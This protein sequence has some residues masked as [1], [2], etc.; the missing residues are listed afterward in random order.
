MLAYRIAWEI[1]KDPATT[2]LYISSTSNL[3]EKQ[4]GAIKNILTS[5]V[6]RRYW[7][8]M[9]HPEEGKREKWSVGEF[10]VDHPLRKEEGVRDPTVFA[11]GLTTAITG[12]HCKIAALDDVVTQE[13]A[14]TEDGRRKVESQYSLLASIEEPDAKELVVGTRYHPRDLYDAMTGMREDVYDE[15]GNI[16]ETRQIYE[17]FE[18][19]VEDRGDGTGEFLWPRQQRSDGQWFGFNTQ[20]LMTKKAQ[21]LDKTQFYAQYYNDPNDRTNAPITPDKFQ[22]FDKKHLKEQGGNWFFKDKKLNVYAGIDFAYS[23]TRKADYTALVVIG[24]DPDNNIYVLDIARFKQDRVQGYY[25]E[26][27]RLYLK[28]SFKKLRAEVTAAQKV[29][30]RELKEKVKQDGYPIKIEEYTPTRNEGTKEERINLTL[31][32]RYDN[33]QVWHYRDG[34]CQ[35]LE[36]EL[37]L[38]FPPH[39]DVKDALASVV[40]IA[41]P[42]RQRHFETPFSTST[43]NLFHSRFGGIH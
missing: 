29:I 26:I 42:P 1:T 28:W 10:S 25:D 38:N 31:Q 22:Y 3:A 6:Y 12:M 43:Q 36:E 39:D 23:L 37:V 2:V 34:N 27:L 21:Y 40:S 18:R 5:K 7:P 30:V 15:D 35:V 14:Y 33:L 19:E 17:K 4:L 32:P 9:V 8:D 16:T 20:I 13:N 11:A 41:N 24:V